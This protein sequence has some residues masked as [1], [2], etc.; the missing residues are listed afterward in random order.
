MLLHIYIY[1]IKKALW[2]HHFR[3]FVRPQVRSR[4]PLNSFQPNL[5]DGPLWIW[6]SVFSVLS[7]NIQSLSD[8][9]NRGFI[10]LGLRSRFLPLPPYFCCLSIQLLLVKML[11]FIFYFLVPTGRFTDQNIAKLSFTTVLQVTKKRYFTARSCTFAYMQNKES[12]FSL[13]RIIYEILEATFLSH[14]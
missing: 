2:A 9:K 12:T 6:S 3:A 8:Y 13:T 11:H 5:G 10:A 1:P 7:Q 14:S 4:Q